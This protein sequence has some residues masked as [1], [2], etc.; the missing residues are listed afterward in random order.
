MV[1]FIFNYYVPRRD[2]CVSA[3]SSSTF[4]KDA[5]KFCKIEPVAAYFKMPQIV[6]VS[7]VL[8]KNICSKIIQRFLYVYICTAKFS[9]SIY[10]KFLKYNEQC[11]K[12]MCSIVTQRTEI[13]S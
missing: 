6:Y 5:S 13:E 11:P 1:D 9:S 12:G 7:N 8:K 4:D 10:W 3:S 2:R